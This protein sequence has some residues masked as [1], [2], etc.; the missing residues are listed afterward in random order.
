MIAVFTMLTFRGLSPMKQ[1]PA[2][3]IGPSNDPRRPSGHD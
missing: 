1:Q 2:D 3:D